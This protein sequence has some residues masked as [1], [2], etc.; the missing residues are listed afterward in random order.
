MRDL[1]RGNSDI[2]KCYQPRTNTVKD[3]KDGL[4]TGS[5]SILAKWRNHCSKL[6]NL[7]VVSDFRQ[8]EIHTT[9]LLLP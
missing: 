5:H 4:I 9:K 8:T 6:L 2:K 7:H 3:K 1:Y